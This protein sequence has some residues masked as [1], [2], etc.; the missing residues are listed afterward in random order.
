MSSLRNAADIAIKKINKA[1]VMTLNSSGTKDELLR[2]MGEATFVLSIAL[3]FSEK[4]K[5]AV[6]GTLIE[7]ENAL[8][9]YVETIEKTGATLNYGHHVLGLLRAAIAAEKG[10]KA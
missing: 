10:E 1:K 4:Q 3:A 9:D 2:L 5:G 8:S 7:A 6:L